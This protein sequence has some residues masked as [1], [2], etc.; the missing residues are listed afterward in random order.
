MPSTTASCAV[1][2]GVGSL[3]GGCT[4]GS[5]QECLDNEPSDPAEGEAR[6]LS[7]NYAFAEAELGDSGSV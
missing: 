4:L 5:N 1:T 2:F 3:S 6:A 7:L